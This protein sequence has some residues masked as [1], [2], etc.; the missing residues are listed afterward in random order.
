MK[1]ATAGE[2]STRSERGIGASPRERDPGRDGLSLALDAVEGAAG[3]PGLDDE[4]LLVGAV[5][6]DLGAA[7][8]RR[9]V[10]PKGRQ[11][12]VPVRL[13]ARPHGGGQLRR[14]IAEL[15]PSRHAPILPA[16]RDSD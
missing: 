11:H 10:P 8:P 5:K 1:T 9:A 3:A 15:L 7:D 4:E 12:V 2:P 14:L 13:E 6:V 16:A